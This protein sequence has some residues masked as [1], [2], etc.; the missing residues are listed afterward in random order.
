M[1]KIRCGWADETEIMRNYHD[2]EWGKPLYDDRKL[3]EFLLLDSFQAGLS[4][5]TI[6]KK[7]NNFR[8]A[9]DDFDY[10]KI[11]K[12]DETKIEQLMQNKGIVRNKMKIL[13]SIKNAKLFQE[14]QKEFGSFSNFIWGFV[15]NAPIINTY[16]S[17][18]EIPATSKESDI[19]SK[20]LKKKGFSFIG[21]TIIYAFMQ[22]AGL[23]DDHIENC[24]C[25]TK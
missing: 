2:E 15:D 20:D 1:K 3:F 13:A 5:L 23:V 8:V 24:F 7:R 14:I 25:K 4:W 19:L 6:L 10:C 16:Q 21:S 18:Q 9:F 11:A 17:W 22:A 12:Y